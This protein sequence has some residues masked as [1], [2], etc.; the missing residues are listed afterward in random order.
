VNVQNGYEL[1]ELH[2]VYAPSPTNGQVLT[3]VSGNSRW[4]AATVADQSATNEL[5]TLSVATNTATL[6][7]SGGSVTIAGGGINTVGTAGSTIT[8]TGT[9]VDGSVTNEIQQIDTF[10]LS[11]QTLRASLSNDNQAAKTVTLP[12]VGI[13]AGTNVTVSSTGGDFTINASGGAP[14]GSTGQIQYSNAGAFGASSNLFWDNANG[15]L[16]VGTNAPALTLDVN[17]TARIQNSAQLATTSGAVI[18]NTTTDDG[19][20]KLQVSG[21]TLLRGTG[22]TLFVQ[23]SSSQNIL[24]ARDDGTILL[25]NSPNRPFLFPASAIS[26][27]SISGTALQISLDNS[28]TRTTTGFDFLI[29]S[30]TRDYTSGNVDV[31][32]LTNA[33]TPTSGSGTM[34]IFA[35]NPTINQTGGASGITRGLHVNP[36]LTAAANWRSIEW[37]NSAGYGIYGSGTAPNYMAGNTSIGVVSASARLDVKSG[38]NSSSTDISNFE[39]SDGTDILRIRSDGKNTYWA[40]NTAAGTTGVQTINRPSGTINI[41]A[42]ESSKDVNNSLCTTSSIVFAVVRTNDTTAYIKNVVPGAG[43]FTINLGA[44]ATTETSVGFFVIN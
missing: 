18:I 37:S 5:Q 8:V 25:G 27:P 34:N 33:F 42:G 31:F 20:N 26:S 43:S 1:E 11:G 35:L 12:V 44:A 14:A 39:N 17:G 22:T 15:R 21:G 13:T 30:G 2:N 28:S 6:S 4:E 36:T 32:R 40:T 9:E 29:T 3:Y 19:V 7:N 38:G 10:S 24:R 41:A 23:N 16:G